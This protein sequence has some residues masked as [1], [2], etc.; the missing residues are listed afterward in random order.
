MEFDKA[1]ESVGSLADKDEVISAITARISKA[2]SS[3]ID[4][5]A[6]LASKETEI[7][8]L[9]ETASSFFTSIGV[10]SYESATSSFSALKEKGGGSAEQALTITK[11]QSEAKT[12]AESILS[13]Q[14][15]NKENASKIEN[16]KKSGLIKASLTKNGMIDSPTMV[17][18]HMASLSFDSQG[19]LVDSNGLGVDKMLEELL[20]V[21]T[22]LKASPIKKQGSN[23]FQS[24]ST[25]GTDKQKQR[26]ELESF[27]G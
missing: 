12:T 7:T 14:N 20:K 15:I 18:A 24:N 23:N 4:Y 19:S 5:K 22:H 8:G 25:G 11:M 3:D 13:L 26:S 10:T 6:S 1:M 27:L 9:K 21:E 16:S 2:N 17:N